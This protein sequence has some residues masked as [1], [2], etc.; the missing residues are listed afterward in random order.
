[1]MQRTSSTVLNVATNCSA[2]NCSASHG[3]T[4]L[5]TPKC[6]NRKVPGSACKSGCIDDV[7]QRFDD[8]WEGYRLQR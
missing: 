8:H 1:M 2:T 6:H 7:T 5:E 3:P 4:R